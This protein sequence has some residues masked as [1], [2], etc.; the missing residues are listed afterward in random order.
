[1]SVVKAEDIH[2]MSGDEVNSF[3]SVRAG[4]NVLR[5]SIMY[6]SQKPSY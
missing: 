1:M 4:G 2:I 3:V 5:T 6:K